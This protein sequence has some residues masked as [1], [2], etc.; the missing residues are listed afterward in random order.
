[1]ARPVV[2]LVFSVVIVMLLILTA[3]PLAWLIVFVG[4][5]LGHGVVRMLMVVWIGCMISMPIISSDRSRGRGHSIDSWCFSSRVIRA[6]CVVQYCLLCIWK[7]IIWSSPT[8]SD[9]N[10]CSSFLNKWNYYLCVNRIKSS[11]FIRNHWSKYIF[12]RS[13]IET[14]H[15]IYVATWFS[16]RGTLFSLQ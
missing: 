1:M 7:N 9:I 8:T 11:S 2:V 14:A 4:K 5:G 10:W 3:D 12:F 6:H 13:P 15:W 16:P